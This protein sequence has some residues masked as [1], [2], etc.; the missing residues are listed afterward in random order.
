LPTQCLYLLNR[1]AGRRDRQHNP[2]K[3]TPL[4][5][6]KCSLIRIATAESSA[7]RQPFPIKPI[8]KEINDPNS[9]TDFSDLDRTITSRKSSEDILSSNDTIDGRDNVNVT[10]VQRVLTADK[11]PLSIQD[12]T[13]GS[14]TK[15][16]KS[17]KVMKLPRIKTTVKSI[18]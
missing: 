3:I 8:S 18:P 1:G 4:K 15:R 16:S 9:L 6:E 12:R 7:P 2:D 17:I 13:P 10:R 11:I 14:S 5:N